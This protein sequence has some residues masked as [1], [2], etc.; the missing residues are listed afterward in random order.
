MAYTHLGGHLKKVGFARLL[1]VLLTPLSIAAEAETL[2]FYPADDPLI[3]ERLLFP[4]ENKDKHRFQRKDGIWDFVSTTDA[5]ITACEPETIAYQGK[6]QTIQAAAYYNEG[7]KNSRQARTQRESRILHTLLSR[8]SGVESMLDMP[9]GG[10]RLSPVLAKKANL[11]VEMDLSLGQLQYG[12]E[13]SS[14]STPRVWIRGS[15]FQIPLKDRSIEGAACIRLSHHLYSME[16]KEKLLSELMRVT[17]S[18][19]ILSFV[20]SGAPKYVLRRLR[21]RIFGRPHRTTAISVKELRAMAKKYGG[22]L[23]A[24]PSLGPFRAHR[25][26]LIRKT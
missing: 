25:Y 7:Y 13:N 6:Y 22:D 12:Q 9:C 16:E 23:L 14:V 8:F 17:R 3:E 21:D 20:D 24:Y 5:R 15:G 2:P 4:E 1:G 26:A 10:G 18:F 19:V 11:L